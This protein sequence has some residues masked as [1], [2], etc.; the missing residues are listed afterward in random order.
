VTDKTYNTEVQKAN[1]C[2]TVNQ[3]LSGELSSDQTQITQMQ[4][5]HRVTMVNEILQSR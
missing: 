1:A 3:R 4:N 2:A 5:E